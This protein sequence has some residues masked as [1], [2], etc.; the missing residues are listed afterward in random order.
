MSR[1]CRSEDSS[2]S[3]N[4]SSLRRMMSS[5]AL[6]QM[7]AGGSRRISTCHRRSIWRRSSSDPLR[8]KTSTFRPESN[9]RVARAV[10]AERYHEKPVL[11]NAF[12]TFWRDLPVDAFTTVI[13]GDRGFAAIPTNDDRRR[14]LPGTGDVCGRNEFADAMS[15]TLRTDQAA[16]VGENHGLHAASQVL[17]RQDRCDM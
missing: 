11:Q 15:G 10:I 5:G 6:T 8:T 4:H 2:P 13:R 16:F 12:Y 1:H 17:F 7:C 14:R 9:S 3:A